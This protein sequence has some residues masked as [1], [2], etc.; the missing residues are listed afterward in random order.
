MFAI[1]ILQGNKIVNTKQKKHCKCCIYKLIE[2]YQPSGIG[3]PK[4]TSSQ[5]A[6]TIKSIADLVAFVKGYDKYFSP[7][8]EVSKAVL[9]PDGT[10]K[11]F[12]TQRWYMKPF[13][14]LLLHK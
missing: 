11:V 12:L 1:S 4:L 9:N 7:A 13:Y 2:K 10:P 14:W 5:T 3:S 6:G 8:P